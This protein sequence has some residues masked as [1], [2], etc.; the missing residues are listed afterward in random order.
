MSQLSYCTLCP[1]W[2]LPVKIYL[3]QEASLGVWKLPEMLSLAQYQVQR[4]ERHGQRSRCGGLTLSL[5]YSRHTAAGTHTRV[6]VHVF[7]QAVCLLVDDR[8]RA[9]L[10][11]SVWV[12]V[13]VSKG[14][15]CSISPQRGQVW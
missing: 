4:I 14:Y 13:C 2:A 6:C 1:S 11:V 9:C 10:C 15:G 5:P 7:L 8:V 12:H 3:P